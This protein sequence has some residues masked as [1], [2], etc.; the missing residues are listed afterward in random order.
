MRS[1]P[2][3]WGTWTYTPVEPRP[4]WSQRR[5]DRVRRGEQ[6]NTA[7]LSEEAVRVVRSEYVAGV[8]VDVLSKRFGVSAV[9]IGN[10]VKRRSWK[11]VP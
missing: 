8:R 3:G 6:I 1:V 11:H 9:Q 10:I 4:H 2:G 7:E 5:P